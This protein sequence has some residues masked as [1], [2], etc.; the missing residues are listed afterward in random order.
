[1]SEGQIHARPAGGDDAEAL[2]APAGGGQRQG[3]AQSIDDV[4]DQI[5]TALETGAESFVEGFVQK[6]GQ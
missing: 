6:G 3:Q 4:L 2:G 1:M 5:D